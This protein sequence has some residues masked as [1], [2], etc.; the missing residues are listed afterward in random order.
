[1][2]DDEQ[3]LTSKI[4]SDLWQ[5]SQPLIL[6][7]LAQLDAAATAAHD[8]LLAEP[9]RAEAESTAHKLSGSLGMFG[10]HKGTECA[11]ALEAELQ[12]ESPNPERLT[13]LSDDLRAS[14]RTPSP[15]S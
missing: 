7:R 15:I 3:T 8:G 13:I 11:R 10:Y 1:M 4:L 12:L 14:L 2:P 5:R 6:E 9:Q